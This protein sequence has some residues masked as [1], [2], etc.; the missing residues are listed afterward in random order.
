[1]VEMPNFCREPYRSAT[2]AKQRDRFFG[3]VLVLSLLSSVLGLTNTCVA[4][5]QQLPPSVKPLPEVTQQSP[6]PAV[7]GV[8]SYGNEIS[9]NGRTLPVA[10]F[11]R[12]EKSGSFSTHLGDGALRQLIGVDLLNSNNPNKQ[13]VQWFSRVKKPVVLN[14]LV[15]SGYRY[16]DITN[17][18]KIMKWQVQVNGNTLII[19]TPAAKVTN[20]TESKP[21]NDVSNT[22]FKET[23]VIVDLDRPT[24]WLVRQ[25]SAVSKPQSPP[26]PIDPD[27]PTPKTP[28]L[29]NR[30][31][32]ITLDGIAD[33][34][35]I[36]RYS[37]P[38]PIPTPIPAPT[39]APLP[40]LVKQL[41][42]VQLPPIPP[43]PPVIRPTKPAVNPTPEPLIKQVEIVNNQTIIRLSVPFGLAPRVS[44]LPKPNRLIIDIRPDAMVERD[45]TWAPGLR[46]R[47]QFVNLGTERFPVVWLEVN[48]RALGLKL[49][50][51][52]TSPNTLIG[53]APLI[54]TAQQYLAVA[55]INGGYFNRN[56][57]YPLGAIRQDNQWLSSP[58]LNRGAIAWN[59]SGKFYFGRLTLEETLTITENNQRFPILFLNSGYVQSGIARYTPAWGTSYTPLTDNEIIVAV[60]KNQIINQL[61][62][63]KAGEI[64]VT[65]PQQGYL[66]AFRGNAVSLANQLPLDSV[67]RLESATTPAE[68]SSYPQIIGAG[69][70]LVQNSQI[71]LDAKSEK[72]GDAFIAEKAI[73]S[74]IC[75]TATDT[76]M[77]TAIHNRAGGAGPTLAEHAQLL[78]QMGCVNALNLDGGSSTGLYLGGQ[79][80]D[81]SPNTAARVHN[82]IGI[83]LQPR[84]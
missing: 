34:V 71:V 40:N 6:A 37:P 54:K 29:P 18:A 4:S 55:G 73:R 81:R 59:D 64:P 16:L 46:W 49:K 42:P 53:S 75:T 56:N 66:L 10:W 41:P 48:P 58:I 43:L 80:L 83:F 33:P 23:R 13:P 12:R 11:Q 47:Q 39:P 7:T 78:Q 45:I 22:P 5:A 8:Q 28:T 72:F 38:A 44:S 27:T 70:L 61:P 2:I 52:L 14:T 76:L 51:I 63:G 82:G 35:L 30:E 84:R 15:A 74:G 69:P 77:I 62:G 1:M 17:F 31:W 19:V 21:A 57:R 79:L 3:K 32:T 36:Q 68:F 25:E 65:I 60:E 9:L 20:I 26:P 50:P 67:V 24:P